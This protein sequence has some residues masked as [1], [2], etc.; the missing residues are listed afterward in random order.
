MI[1]KNLIGALT[2]GSVYALL[3]LGYSLIYQASGLMTFVQ[4][5]LF[6]LGAVVG[7][8]LYAYLKIPFI[9]AFVLT[10]IGMFFFGL[11]IEKCVIRILLKKEAAVIYVVLSTIALSIMLQN[12][13]M[14]VWGSQLL[15]FPPIFAVSNIKIG[16]VSIIPESLM[17][18]GMALVS[19]LL[20]HIFINKSKFGTAMRAAAQDP[21][22]AATMGIDVSK[23]TSIT[24]G[25]SA[26]LAGVAGLIFSPIYAASFV[27]GVSPGLKGFAGAVIGGYGN[28][29]GAIV[30]SLF[31]SLTETFVAGYISSG[32]K[33]FI[34]FF[35]LILILFIK[36]RG[37]FN[38][39]VLGD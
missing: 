15:F 36:P 24:W 38:A 18:F 12:F 9:I 1:V 10:I 22:A 2:I 8:A 34:S 11:L 25:I 14:L 7:L 16:S 27:M 21:M 32:Y 26:A 4:G 3:A 19:M 35:I 33:D 30:G 23:T 37:I 20:L 31:L 5:D 6:M 29:Y 13:V 28:M 39:D 17:G